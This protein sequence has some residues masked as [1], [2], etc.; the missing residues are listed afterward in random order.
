MS[1]VSKLRD[2]YQREVIRRFLAE[3]MCV[4]VNNGHF[5]I[6]RRESDYGTICDSMQSAPFDRVIVHRSNVVKVDPEPVGWVEISYEGDHRTMFTDY[7]QG[8]AFIMDA[9]DARI[10]LEVIPD[11][12]RKA[13]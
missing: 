2:R 1:R 11:A 3:G 9:F 8:I 4:T 5:D 10:Q 12:R 7:S 6:C 13:A